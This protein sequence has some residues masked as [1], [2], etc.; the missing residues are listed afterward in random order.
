VDWSDRNGPQRNGIYVGSL[1]SDAS[2]LISSDMSGN[3]AFSLGNL[4]SV[5]DRTVMAQ[6]FDTDALRLTGPL[7]PLTQQE[8][9]KFSD[10]Q[11]SGVSVSQDGKIVFQSAADVPSRLIWYDSNGKEI[12]QV[13]Q[14][15]YEGPQFSPDGRSL[16]AYVDD[17]RNGKHFIRVLDLQSGISRRLTEGGGETLPVWSRDGKSIAYRNAA[18]SIDVVAADGSQP[19]HPLISGVNVI[20]C[21]WSLDDHLVYMSLEGGSFP[22]LKVFSLSDGKSTQLTKSGAEPQFSPDGKWIAYIELPERQIMVQPFPGPG[23]R[24]QVSKSMGSNQ[25]RWSGNGRSIYFIQSDRKMMVAGFDPIRMV[26]SA[27]RL[28]TQT[29]VIAPM[30]TWFQ[31]AVAPDGRF[32]VNSLPAETSSPLTLLSGWPSLL[33]PN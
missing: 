27:P 12:G 33:P 18:L 13:A 29:R 3:V 24:I 9:D 19:P 7:T 22:S 28:V 16:A 21:D 31:Y 32:L 23:P 25:P 20:P 4:L 10:F 14:V 17:E 30:F 26:S 1:D 15:G 2:K 8:V 6:S 5:R 11:E